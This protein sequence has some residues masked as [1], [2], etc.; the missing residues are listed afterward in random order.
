MQEVP[1]LRFGQHLSKGIARCVVR[2][3]IGRVDA[4]GK[5]VLDAIV[6]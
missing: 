5:R 4:V 1:R 6:D 3:K 2:I